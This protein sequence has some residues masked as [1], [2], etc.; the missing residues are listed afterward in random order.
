MANSQ[1]Q[2]T[3]NGITVSPSRLPLPTALPQLLYKDNKGILSGKIL[4][5]DQDLYHMI[6]RVTEYIPTS[7][8]PP[9]ML[10]ARTHCTCS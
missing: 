6:L 2:N 8:G 5:E 1:P 3:G 7:Q 4:Y 10:R 9:P